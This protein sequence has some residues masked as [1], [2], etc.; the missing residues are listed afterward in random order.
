MYTKSGLWKIIN[1]TRYN[2]E[3]IIDVF[4]RAEDFISSLGPLVPARTKEEGQVMFRDYSPASP[5]ITRRVFGSGDIVTVRLFARGADYR[6]RHMRDVG[7]VKPTKLYD[8]PLEALA[9][10]RQDGHEVVPQEFLSQLLWDIV[11]PCYV[12]GMSRQQVEQSNV[13]NGARVRVMRNKQDKRPTDA[14]RA[15]KLSALATAHSPTYWALRS[16]LSHIEVVETAFSGLQDRFDALNLP[17]ALTPEMVQECVRA[18]K[19]VQTALRKD[20]MLIRGELQ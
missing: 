9:A 19:A 16:A 18:M 2:T 7:L 1:S 13:L 5:T 10:A 17:R 12:H 3:D 8:S 4:N 6:A 14:G 11:M 15:G 20:D